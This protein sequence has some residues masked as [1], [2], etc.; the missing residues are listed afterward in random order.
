MGRKQKQMRMIAPI[1]AIVFDVGGTLEDV[2]YD[3]AIRL[4]AARG[5][6]ALMIERDLDPGMTASELHDVIRLGL[7][8]YQRLRESANV[9]IPPERVWIDY[10]FAGRRLP[11]DRLTEAAEDLMFYYE[12]HAFKRTMKAEAPAAI[13]ALHRAGFRLAIISNVMSRTLMPRNLDA[14]GLT[15]YFDPIITSAGMGIRKPHPRIFADTARQ[16]HLAPA[17]CAYVGDTISRDVAG[18]QRAGYGMTIQIKSFLTS[19]SDRDSDTERPDAVVQ[20]L[21]EIGPLIAALNRT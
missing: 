6:R 15:R 12:N 21:N 11:A 13:A 17:V 14:Y 2:H 5:L 18:A 1:R 9:E 7:D 20:N 19:R 8:A 10:V 16:M 3:D 4:D